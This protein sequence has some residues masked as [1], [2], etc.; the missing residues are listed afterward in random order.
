MRRI[1]KIHKLDN[2]TKVRYQRKLKIRKKEG[3]EGGGEIE[4]RKKGGREEKKEVGR[5]EGKKE[6]QKS[7]KVKI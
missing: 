3:K 2:E 4:E 6:D 7:N 1:S 5:K